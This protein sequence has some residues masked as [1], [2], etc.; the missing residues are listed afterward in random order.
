MT[1]LTY[2]CGICGNTY[3]SVAERVKCEQACLVKQELEAKK[4]AEAK[5]KEE[6]KVR[7]AEVNQAIE[8]AAKI[9]TQYITDYGSFKYNGKSTD[10][11]NLL[12]LDF[13]PTK[14]SHH[15]MF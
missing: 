7:E 15:F 14:I 13:L 8:N 10:I 1:K 6:Q 12:F 9:L 4:A 11:Q 5:K 3:D 2:Q